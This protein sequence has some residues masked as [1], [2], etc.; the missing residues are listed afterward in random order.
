MPEAIARS[1]DFLGVFGV[2]RER[3]TLQAEGLDQLWRG[4]NTLLFSATIRWPSTI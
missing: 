4:R 1:N 3:T 2:E